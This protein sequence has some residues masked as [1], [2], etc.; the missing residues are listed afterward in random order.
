M[1]VSKGS[2]PFFKDG[3]YKVRIV[4]L[5]RLAYDLHLVE[6]KILQADRFDVFPHERRVQL[7]RMPEHEDEWNLVTE[8]QNE[9]LYLL[10]ETGWLPNAISAHVWSTEPLIHRPRVEPLQPPTVWAVTVNG[11][12]RSLATT[13]SQRDRHLEYWT[14]RRPHTVNDPPWHVH[15]VAFVPDRLP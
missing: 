6:A 2:R 15:A 10:V 5:E 14:S 8:H 1:P 12:T 11:E 9:E 3:Y 4:E 7:M 13:E